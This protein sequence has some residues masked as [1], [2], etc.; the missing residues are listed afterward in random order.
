MQAISCLRREHAALELD[1][2]EA[3]QVDHAPG[4]RH[5]LLRADALAP[6]VGRIGLA[7][8]LGVLEEQVGAVGHAGAHRA[9]QQVDDGR[10]DDLALQVEHRDFEGADRLGR[11]LGAVGSGRQRE[12]HR[13]RL[14][15]D[16]GAQRSSI[17]FRR[18]ATGPARARAF[19]QHRQHGRVAIGFVDADA[20]VGGLH[21]M[22]RAAPR[23]RG[24][25]RR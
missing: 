15:T 18:R 1:A 6:G 24:C 22:M 17:R 7:M 13:A 23:A 12:F 16:G 8:V 5:D 14:G 2:L 10:A 19:L 21:S 11:V 4:L 20:A 25:R 3:V 9:A